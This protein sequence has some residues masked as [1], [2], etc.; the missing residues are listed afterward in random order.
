[1][2]LLRQTRQFACSIPAIRVCSFDQTLRVG[3]KRN[4]TLS[5][6]SPSEFSAAM[7]GFF[8]IASCKGLSDGALLGCIFKGGNLGISLT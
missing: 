7:L 1:M 8:W 2:R 4:F 5:C 6:V 3:P